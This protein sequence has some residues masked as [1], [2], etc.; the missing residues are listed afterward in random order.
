VLLQD[1]LRPENQGSQSGDW[2]VSKGVVG[3]PHR[4]PSSRCAPVRAGENEDGNLVVV[5]VAVAKRGSARSHTHTRT[6]H[7]S[8]LTKSR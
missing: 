1:A 7:D 2:T 4:K 6:C 5:V 3:L 8:P